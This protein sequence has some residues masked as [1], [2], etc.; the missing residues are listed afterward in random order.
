M[1][2]LW[3]FFLAAPVRDVSPQLRK[4]FDRSVTSDRTAFEKKYKTHSKKLT[5]GKKKIEER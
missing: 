4:P 3:F 1:L 2:F 5:Q